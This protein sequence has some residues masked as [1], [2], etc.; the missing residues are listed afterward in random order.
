[1]PR[2]HLGTSSM[3]PGLH[4]DVQKLLKSDHLIFTFQNNG[5]IKNC[6]NEYD[7]HIMGDFKCTNRKCTAKGWSSKKIAITIRQFPENQYNAT[8]FHQRCSRCKWLS[9]PKLDTSYAERVA[10]RL[11]KWSGVPVEP[12]FFSGESKGPHHQHLCEGCKAGHCQK[13]TDF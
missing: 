5:N 9:K 7:T 3:Y 4:Q 6:S 13:L 12:P 11:K 10:Y 2:A 8:V 1:M